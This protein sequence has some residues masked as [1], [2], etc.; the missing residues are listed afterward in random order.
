LFFAK[1][2][3]AKKIQKVWKAYL[4]W[5]EINKRIKDTHERK[6]VMKLKRILAAKII[7][8]NVKKWYQRKRARV[9]RK[10]I[11]SKLINV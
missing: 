2:A 5:K 1:T 10:A 3:A 8:R 11:I 9:L 6:K 4:L 7:V